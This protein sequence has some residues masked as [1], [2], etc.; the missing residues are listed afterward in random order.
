MF[1][2]KAKYPTG[3]ILNKKTRSLTIWKDQIF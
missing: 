3:Y 2:L 1:W